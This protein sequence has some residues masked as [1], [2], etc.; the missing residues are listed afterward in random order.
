[1]KRL[2][3]YGI[4]VLIGI[5]EKFNGFNR[6]NLSLT[7]REVKISQRPFAKGKLECQAYGF[8]EKVK[9]G[10]LERKCDIYRLSNR[11]RKF[12]KEPKKLDEIE[13]LLEEIEKEQRK[14]GG[15]EKRM[16]INSLRKQV[17]KP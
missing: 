16:R 6:D 7:Y 11:W 10:G 1:M 5:Y 9:A 15:K 4:Y 3:P 14:P 2:S 17:L 13:Q 8:I 12:M